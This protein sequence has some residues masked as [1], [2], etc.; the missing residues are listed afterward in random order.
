VSAQ[1]GSVGAARPT[2]AEKLAPGAG[3]PV[4]ARLPVAVEIGGKEPVCRF[5]D[6]ARS[7]A[8]GIRFLQ[9][10]RLVVGRPE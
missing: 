2:G 7:T 5:D 4:P 3:L 10:T 9:A 6:S 8:P 1:T